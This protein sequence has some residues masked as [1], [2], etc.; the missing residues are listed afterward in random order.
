MEELRLALWSSHILIAMNSKSC[1]WHTLMSWECMSAK[2]MQNTW[3]HLYKWL[4]SIFFLS[5]T[6]HSYQS[7]EALA[8]PSAMGNI[9]Q[10]GQSICDGD[11]LANLSLME[12][13]GALANP[14]VMG[15]IVL[16][17]EL[18]CPSLMGIREKLA[19][20]SVMGNMAQ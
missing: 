2:Y 4:Q 7:S 5:L 10:T 9:A 20:P 19:K 13:G 12:I 11:K 14:S 17:W 3:N 6:L 8:S 15:N 1:I 18:A 16:L